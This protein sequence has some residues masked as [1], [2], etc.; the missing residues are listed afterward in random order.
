MSM[1]FLLQLRDKEETNMLLNQEIWD[2]FLKDIEHRDILKDE[3][4]WDLFKLRRLF[5]DKY[6]DEAPDIIT[7]LLENG[8]LLDDQTEIPNSFFSHCKNL[9]N[10][11]LPSNLKVIH[12]FVF[13]QCHNLKDIDIPKTVTIIGEYAF[14]NC[15]S[16]ENIVIPETTFKI[17]EKAFQGCDNLIIYCESKY[18]LSQWDFDWNPDGRPVYYAG[19]WKYI[20]GV[21]TPIKR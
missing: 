6:Y 5:Y 1:E 10:V 8:N 16:L 18:K 17:G 13:C 9:T 4:K 14:Y 12:N 11:E 15:E 20:N 2:Q 21:P 3:D 19:E 7:I